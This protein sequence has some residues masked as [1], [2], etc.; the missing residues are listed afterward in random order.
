MAD[1]WRAFEVAV[2]TFAQALEPKAV[3][4]HDAKLPD[5]DTG[6]LRQRDVWIET[7]YGGHLKI[8]VLVSCKHKTA[9]LNQQDIDAFAGELRSSGAHKGVLYSRSGYTKPALEKA[10][11][12]GVS[13]CALYDNQ[14]AEIP[15]ALS[16]SAYV[17][18][19][20]MQATVFG[21][22]E[23]RLALVGELFDLPVIGERGAVTVAGLLA[24]RFDQ[25][26]KNA[27]ERVLVD[28]VPPMWTAEVEVEDERLHRP[29]RVLLR[30]GWRIHRA[31]TKAFLVNGSYSFTDKDFKGSFSTPSIDTWSVHPGPGWEE[32]DEPEPS[33]G[34]VASVIRWGGSPM[35]VLSAMSAKP[36]GEVFHRPR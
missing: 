33:A 19:E 5:L 31:R 34:I 32:I 15:S 6:R 36:F 30:S 18:S 4:V 1:D 16:F 27:V 21:N 25:Q 12:L 13:C 9:K 11:R 10:E 20:V 22:P 8:R 23:Q 17:Y 3:V 29:A 7:S 28:G 35:E 2:A 14:P 24:E 26:R